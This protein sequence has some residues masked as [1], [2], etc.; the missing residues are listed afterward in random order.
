MLKRKIKCLKAVVSG[1]RK[2]F[3]AVLCIAIAMP[4]VAFAEKTETQVSGVTAIASSWVPPYSADKAVDNSNTSDSRWYSGTSGDKWLMLD[5]KGTYYIGKWQ[6]DGLGTAG[7]NSSCNLSDYLFQGS[8]DGTNWITLDSVTGNTVNSTTRT[9]SPASYRYVRLYITKGNQSNNYWASVSEF[10]VF[11]VSPVVT[12]V[13]VPEAKTYVT[14][15]NMDFTV[16]FSSNVTVNTAGGTPNLPITLDSGAVNAQYISG[17]GTS[18][19]VFRYTVASGD[20]DTTGIECGTSVICNGGAIRDALGNDANLTLQ[21]VGSTS[22]ILVDAPVFYTVSVGSLTGGSIVPSLSTATSGT[23]VTL[24]VTPESGM[25]LKA[26]TLKYN[27]GNG[28]F[29][30]GGNSFAMPSANVTITAEFE[31]I[32]PTQYTVSV[33]SLTGGSIVPSLSTAT[34]GTSVTLTVTPESGMQLKA[35]TLKYNDGSNDY[36]ITGNSFTMPS[37]NVTITAEFESIPPTQ[38]AV[39]VGSLTGGSIVPS[40]ST[41]TEG[42]TVT[43]DITPESGMQLK[44]GTLKYDDAM[45]SYD[46]TGNSF[47]MPSANVTITAE[48]ESI[49]PTQYTVSVGS[50]TGGSIVPSVSTATSGT[51]VT[52]TVTPESGMQLKTGTLKYNDG[53]GDF[54]IGGNSFAMPSANV[55]ITAEF[56]SIPLTQYTVTFNE[57]G[58]TTAANPTEKAVI[59][60]ATVSLPTPPT[61]SGY[62]FDGWNTLADGTGVDFTASTVVNGNIT[63]YAQWTLNSN[64]GTTTPSTYTV[65]FNENGGTTAANPTEKAVIEGEA[66]SLP[67]PPTQ[68]GYTF[69]GW[70]TLADGTGVDFTAST[71]VNGNITVYAQWTINSN[72]GTTTP[73]TYTVTFNEN[74][75]TT[76]ANPTEKTVLEGET[77]SLP[78]PPTRSGYTF[79]GWNTLADGT[80]VDFTVSTVVNGNMTVYAKWIRRSSGGSSEGGSSSSANSSANTAMIRESQPNQPVTAVSSIIATVGT[81]GTASAP[82]PDKAVTDA[83]EK[84][85]AEAAKGNAGNGISVALNVTMPTGTTALTATLSPNAL[86]NLLSAGVTNLEINSSPVIINFDPKALLEIQKQ[87]SGSLNIDIV[88]QQNLPETAQAMIGSR[89]VFDITVGYGTNSTVSNFRDGAATIEIPYIAANGEVPSGLYA[90]YVDENENAMRVEGSFYDA[91]RERVIFNTHHLSMYGVGYTAP[92]EML[93]DTNHHWAKE[94]IDYVVD[95]EILLGT[96]ETTFAPDTAMTREMLVS[97]LGRLAEVDTSDYTTSSFTD[98]ELGKDSQTYIEWAFEKGIIHGIGNNE[99]APDRAITREEIAV[100]IANFAKATGYTLPVASEANTYADASDIGEYYVAAVTAM[101]QAGIMTGDT[102]KNFNPKANATRAEVSSMLYRYI[103]QNI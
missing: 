57:N 18:S 97:A 89:P 1:T 28:D 70:N 23:S 98:V 74:G 62:T 84:A 81:N 61:Q 69:D 59:E 35:D 38:Y 42:T 51:A 6:V 82:I 15:D 7:W 79:G 19:I 80:G 29:V 8:T 85:Q 88:Q 3:L 65:T 49:P 2:L 76:A 96:S 21:G 56:E 101:Q 31:I 47:S 103:Q 43:L 46:I 67:T 94:S 34:S 40:E 72:G 25:Q 48:F 102:N 22:G 36:A 41:T 64:G 26:D 12:S 100:I 39:S 44:A 86:N 95:K 58:G 13:D 71:V 11:A 4:Q 60:G 75:G 93:T 14:G 16:N 63:V 9:I 78:T 54:A 20:I 37:A 92:S 53:N 30:I 90:V 17:T 91:T 27:D 77:V 99:F 24:T 73:S 52:L 45:G 10:K 50:L 66:V 55:T 83:I 68:S 5:L 32:P 33:G 87:S